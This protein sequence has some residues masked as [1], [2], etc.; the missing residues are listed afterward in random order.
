VRK[1]GIYSGSFDPVH[2]G[3]VAFAIQAANQCGLDKVFFMVEPSPRRKQGV[4]ALEH[5]EAMVALAL[6]PYKILSQIILS[7]DRFT[8]E[9][10]LPQLLSRFKGAK[11][12]FLM[13]DDVFTRLQNWGNIN[14]LVET[15]EFIVGT[16]TY[17]QQKIFNHQKLLNNLTGLNTRVQ[18]I[19]TTQNKVA[20]RS[21]RAQ[22]KTANVTGISEPVK[23]YIFR[24]G[25]YHSTGMSK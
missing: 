17:N 22:L 7:Q 12:Y 5:R 23:E 6:K 4:K 20:S 2:D 24:H 15:V 19:S 1:V 9:L 16:R 14:N 13:G 18:L 8:V 11:L 3:H 25:L 21:I 10:T